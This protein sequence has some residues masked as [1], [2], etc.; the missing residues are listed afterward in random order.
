[1]LLIPRLFALHRMANVVEIFDPNKVT[2]LFDVTR[3]ASEYAAG[4]VGGF[5]NVEL[6]LLR[7]FRR[8]QRFD[9]VCYCPS[10]CYAQ[11]VDFLKQNFAKPPVCVSDNYLAQEISIWRQRACLMRKQR[12]RIARLSC[13]LVCLWFK[14]CEKFCG[15]R[16]DLRKKM[17]T[18][19][20]AFSTFDLIPDWIKRKRTYMVIHDTVPLT[21]EGAWCCHGFDWH[22]YFGSLSPDYYYFAIS[23]ATKKDFMKYLHL[24]AERIKVTLLASSTEFYQE[25][26]KKK[27]SAVR[28]KYNIPRNAHYF[29][30]IGRADPRKNLNRMIKNFVEHIHKYH[31]KDLF[32]V[33]AGQKPDPNVT[34]ILNELT[35]KERSKLL[36]IEFVDTEDLAALYSGAMGFIFT[37]KCEGFGL[38]ALEAMQCGCPLITANNS[39]LPEV[40][41]NA[42]ITIDCDSDGEHLAAYADLYFHPEIRANLSARG[43]ARAKQFSWKKTAGLMIDKM[44]ADAYR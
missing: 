22:S 29:F 19:D 28:L 37:S 25:K 9:I 7:Q 15:S 10:Y 2:M 6:N 31:I 4:R 16:F 5:Y 36:Y 27:I 1:M 38:P 18:F 33:I 35:P 34:P 3:L 24:P 44:L 39:S 42:A 43:L 23:Q 26:R 11:G 21:P 20:I 30:T 12:R 32:F 17:P 40:V 13:Q 41:G 8:D 14:Y